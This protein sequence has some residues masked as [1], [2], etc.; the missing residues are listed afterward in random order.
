MDHDSANIYSANPLAEWHNVYTINIFM[1]RLKIIDFPPLKPIKPAN[2]LTLQLLRI[3]SHSIIAVPTC[4][5]TPRHIHHP[6]NS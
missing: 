6:I 4:A 1:Q 5:D 2:L 3:S